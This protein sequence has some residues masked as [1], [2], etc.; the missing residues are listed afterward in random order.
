MAWV[1]LG[2]N[3]GP[4]QKWNAPGQSLEGV[5]V[6][7]RD[8]KQFQG[9]AGK[10]KLAD[11]K[12]DDGTQITCGAPTALASQLSQVAPGARIKI[13]YMGEAV[14]QGGT[15]YKNFETYVLTADA[16]GAVQ[17]PI[18]APPVSTPPPSQTSVPPQQ[19][20]AAQPP[21]ATHS[22]ETLTAIL[23]AAKGADAGNA[24]ASAIKSMEGD[25]VER[26]KKTLTAQGVAF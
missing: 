13:T 2:G 8:G 25:P 4:I 9:N 5:F 24:I 22:F 14:G 16:P 1:K 10:S 15:K 20:V 3:N 6:G 19:P 23:I 7:L 18:A 26:L 12:K 11:L 21:A 17:P